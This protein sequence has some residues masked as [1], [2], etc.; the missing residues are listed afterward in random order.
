MAAAIVHAAAFYLFGVITDWNK[1]GIVFPAIL[2]LL[3][4]LRSRIGWGLLVLIDSILTPITASSVLFGK[5]FRRRF[6]ALGTRR[7][8]AH[9]GHREA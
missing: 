3:P 7:R 1:R 8:G 4:A 6:P 2:V 9:H 5:Q